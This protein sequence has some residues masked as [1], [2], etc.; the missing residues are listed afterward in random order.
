MIACPECGNR[1][2]GRVGLWDHLHSQHTESAAYEVRCECG[3]LARLI[4]PERRWAC[5]CGA[6]IPCRH[7]SYCPIGTPADGATATLRAEVVTELEA[8]RARLGMSRHQLYARLARALKIE[9]QCSV[10]SF[11]AQQCVD[12]IGALREIARRYEERQR[13]A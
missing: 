5:E 6:W 1:V 12:A 11:G 8:V 10:N 3:G 2:N 4:P 13:A 7:G 9:G